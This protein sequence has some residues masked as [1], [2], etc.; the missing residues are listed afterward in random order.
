MLS[1]QEVPP[2]RTFSLTVLFM[3]ALLLLNACGASS[4]A[5]PYTNMQTVTALGAKVAAQYGEMNPKI[6]KVSATLTDGA[7]AVPMNSVALD[8]QF[9]KGSLVAT[10]LSFSMLSD[11]SKV[12]AIFATD[13]QYTI[14][15]TPVWLDAE[16]AITL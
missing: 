12:W 14:T 2:M 1:Y 5:Q 11:G 3:F 15:H 6:T 10:H 16:S 7:T 8:G 13:D 4:T 9:H